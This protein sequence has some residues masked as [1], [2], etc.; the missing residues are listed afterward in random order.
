LTSSPTG[1]MTFNVTNAPTTDGKV[2]TVSVFCTQGGSAS[3]PTTLTV[4]GSAATIKWVSSSTPSG[5]ASGKIDIF[6]FTLI[7]RASAWTVL[8]AATTNF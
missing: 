8:G 7:R 1:S 6:S 4:N 2:F 3:V 5:S